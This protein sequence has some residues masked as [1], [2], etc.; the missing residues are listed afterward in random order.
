MRTTLAAVFAL[1]ALAG[2]PALA[3]SDQASFAVS[4]R[5]ESLCAVGDRQARVEVRCTRGT[6][7]TVSLGSGHAAAA[8][9]DG[10]YPVVTVPASG[11]VTATI[12][13]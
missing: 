10:T 4:A 12:T 13:Y 5:V 7:Y 11:I 8:R 1:T 2:Q 9:R 6:S 3:A